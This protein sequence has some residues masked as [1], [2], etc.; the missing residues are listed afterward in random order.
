MKEDII[1]VI[2]KLTT[3]DKVKKIIADIDDMHP[4]D[5]SLERQLGDVIQNEE[6]LRQIEESYNVQLHPNALSETMT[7]LELCVFI[8]K[9]R[10]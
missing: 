6:F 2:N 10:K 3:I 1:N 8:E 4:M 9:I 5:I 7:I